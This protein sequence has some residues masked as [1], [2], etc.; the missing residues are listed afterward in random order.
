MDWF[1]NKAQII[2]TV[3]GALSAWRALFKGHPATS[4]TSATVENAKFFVIQDAYFERNDEPNI[5]Y[6]RKLR[7]VLRNESGKDVLIKA[8]RWE[9]STGDIAVQPLTEHSWRLEGS[10]G[11]ENGSWGPERWGEAIHVTPGRVLQTWIGLLPS[12]DEV[13][14]RRRHETRRLGT[15]IIPFNMDGHD[16]EQRIRL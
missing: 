10:G 3:T 5:V 11:W 8:A 14:V 12:A 16:K 9:T 7:I 1:A 13:D 15:L 6:K 2:Q 4:E